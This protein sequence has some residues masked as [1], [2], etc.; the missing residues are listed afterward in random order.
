MLLEIKSLLVVPSEQM[1][2]SVF[3]WKYD[4]RLVELLSSP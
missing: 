4:E 2:A 3:Q 1:R